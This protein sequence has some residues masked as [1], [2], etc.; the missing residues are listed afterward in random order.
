MTQTQYDKEN[1]VREHNNFCHNIDNKNGSTA[2]TD[3][4]FEQCQGKHEN[5]T[6]EETNKDEKLTRLQIEQEGTGVNMLQ[7]ERGCAKRC[8]TT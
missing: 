5:Y 1:G 3:K 7:Q 2:M 8:D 4:P 6:L